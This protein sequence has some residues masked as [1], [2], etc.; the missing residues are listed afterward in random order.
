[1]RRC[2]MPG[3]HD[4]YVFEDDGTFYVRPAVAIVTNGPNAKL[5]IRNLTGHK[6]RVSLPTN[7]R[8]VRSSTLRPGRA[9]KPR[10]KTGASGIFN[11]IV[12]VSLK[13]GVWVPAMGDSR[14]KIIVD[15]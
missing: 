6:V 15:P 10:V 14:P 8:T 3:M 7:L 9:A 4:V 5:K 2:P 13:P 12:E 1:M 11:Y